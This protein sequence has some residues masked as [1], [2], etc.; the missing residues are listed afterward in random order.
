[1]SGG[2]GGGGFNALSAAFFACLSL[3]QNQIA[4]FIYYSLLF[5][6]RFLL[7]QNRCLHSRIEAE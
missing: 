2:G 1:M 3:Q 4:Y 7:L 6:K 5:N